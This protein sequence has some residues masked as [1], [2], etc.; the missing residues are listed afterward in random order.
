M[1]T[2]STEWILYLSVVR[3]SLS[4]KDSSSNPSACT[5][6]CARMLAAMMYIMW[7]FW[8]C[9]TH[10]LMCMWRS[11]NLWTNEA[12]ESFDHLFGLLRIYRESS[13]IASVE[14]TRFG[15]PVQKAE[16]VTFRRACARLGLQL[17]LHQEDALWK[18]LFHIS[19]CAILASGFVKTGAFHVT[20]IKVMIWPC[21]ACVKQ[22]CF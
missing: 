12:N 3:L 15:D 5:Q 20:E 14:D 7:I 10:I 13:G 19:W 6:M 18:K 17:H 9:M 8:S 16:A 21:K 4:G 22:L 11:S 2:T 1:Y